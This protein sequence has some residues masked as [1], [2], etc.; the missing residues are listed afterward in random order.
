MQKSYEVVWANTAEND[1]F[2][3]L[4]YIAENNPGN[5]LNILK[6]IKKQVS[7]LYFYPER[8]RIVL[9][10]YNHGIAQY[11]EMIISPWRVVYRVS[12]STVFVLSVL[13]S[14]QNIEDILLKRY[15][16]HII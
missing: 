1:L 14:R 2:K 10:L 6:K 9:E 12:E 15:T 16:Q 4:E 13:D 8:C 11:R 7:E 3:I 5:A